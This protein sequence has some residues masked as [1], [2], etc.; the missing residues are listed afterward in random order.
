[1]PLK[2]RKLHLSNKLCPTVGRVWAF[3]AVS[4]K[5]KHYLNMWN[6]CYYCLYR[7][8]ICHTLLLTQVTAK[9]GMPRHWHHSLIVYCSSISYFKVITVGFLL[10]LIYFKYTFY[11]L[12][13]I[14]IT[15]EFKYNI[16]YVMLRYIIRYILMCLQ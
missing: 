11:E 4:V 15:K 12:S 3:K 10:I 7:D 16:N 2:R 1:M 8:C 6:R 13:V 5:F 14:N 9:K